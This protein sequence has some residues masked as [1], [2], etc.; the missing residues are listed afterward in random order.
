MR[1]IFVA[2]LL[3]LSTSVF[4]V[5]Q[6]DMAPNFKLK[7][8]ASGKAETL[9]EYRGKVVYL[10]FWASWC[11]PCRQSL[12]LLNDLRKELKR[13]GFEVI[14]VNLD[15][16][17]SDAKDFLKQFPVQYPVLL[18]SKGTVPAKYNL[19]GMPTSYLIDRKGLVQ[20]VH[21]GFKETDM[22]DIRKSVISLLRQ[23]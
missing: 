21:I 15:E 3:C 10:D 9:K 14:A 5:S 8:L 16:N 20:K 4:A 6:G 17:V 1:G 22:D 23:K 19:P 7:N 11:G 12:P 2:L 13:K 18:D